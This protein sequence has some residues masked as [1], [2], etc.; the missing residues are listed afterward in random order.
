MNRKDKIV[1]SL[2]KLE[3]MWGEYQVYSSTNLK[4]YL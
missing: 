1:D 3:R 4:R 2:D